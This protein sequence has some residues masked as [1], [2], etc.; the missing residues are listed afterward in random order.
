MLTASGSTASG[1]DQTAFLVDQSFITAIR[2]FLSFGFRSVL[3]IFLQCT[4]YTVLPSVDALAVQ[5]Q[6]T[7]QLDNLLD[8][9]PVT[10]Y[11]GNQFCIVP[12]FLVEL[13]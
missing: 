9:H 10:E 7:Y 1:T 13:L 3:N 11:A 5:L 12:V 8:R 4:F 2:A 6:R